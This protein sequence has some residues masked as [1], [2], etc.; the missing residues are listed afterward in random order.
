MQHGGGGS[1]GRFTAESAEHA[2]RRRHVSPAKRARW[3]VSAMGG[4]RWVHSGQSDGGERR[5]CRGAGTG[6]TL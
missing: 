5:H 4:A 3:A 6:T 2:E 1:K